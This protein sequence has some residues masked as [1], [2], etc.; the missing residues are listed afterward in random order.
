VLPAAAQPESI[1]VVDEKSRLLIS[2][3]APKM[4]T[5]V[6]ESMRSTTRRFELGNQQP[7]MV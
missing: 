6:P 7:W 1:T 4:E 3:Y 5:G 2:C